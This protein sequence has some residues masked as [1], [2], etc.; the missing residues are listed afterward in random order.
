MAARE[1]ISTMAFLKNT[2]IGGHF[3]RKILDLEQKIKT[4]LYLR[5]I[6]NVT[7]PGIFF[8]SNIVKVVHF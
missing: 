4:I 7:T 6:G 1:L 3:P 2:S 8:K 5:T